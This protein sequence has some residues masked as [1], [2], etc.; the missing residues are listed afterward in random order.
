MKG[1]T[2]SWKIFRSVCIVQLILVAFKAMMSFGEVLFRG[3]AFLGLINIIAYALVFV[4]VYHGLS[5]LNYN[6]PDVP[7]SQK[8]KRSFNILYILNFILIAFLFAQ[9]VNTWGMWKVLFDPGIYREF[10]INWLNFTIHLLFPWGIFL[11]H[12]VFL[13]GMFRLRR[14]IHENTVNTWYEQFDQKP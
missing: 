11:I 8:Q 12:F 2:T 7:L 4:F 10:K 3:S 14:L 1:F 5:M 13:T 9:V 6:Y